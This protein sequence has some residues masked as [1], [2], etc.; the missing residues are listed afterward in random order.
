M[1]TSFRY[2]EKKKKEN[3]YL[4]LWGFGQGLGRSSGNRAQTGN[5]SIS[6]AVFRLPLH[7][8]RSATLARRL[9]PP[10]PPPLYSLT[11]KTLCYTTPC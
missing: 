8:R 4:F 3:K 11:T 2:S 6:A 5:L 10:V 1:G 9:S 7:L